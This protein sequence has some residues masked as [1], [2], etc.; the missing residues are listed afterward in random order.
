MVGLP[1]DGASNGRVPCYE[2][3]PEITRRARAMA[4]TASRDHIDLPGW[5]VV[6]L[7][8]LLFAMVGAIFGAFLHI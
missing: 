3:T 6:A 2:F 7:G 5:A 1:G 8:G 4:I